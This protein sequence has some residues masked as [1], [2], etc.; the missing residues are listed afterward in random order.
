MHNAS[1]L[2]QPPPV[3]GVKSTST[4]ALCGPVLFAVTIRYG[5]LSFSPP[6]ESPVFMAKPSVIDASSE[7]H[8]SIKS[9]IQHV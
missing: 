8:L 1:V 5:T 7:S 9:H 2:P 6:V 4:P 3:D